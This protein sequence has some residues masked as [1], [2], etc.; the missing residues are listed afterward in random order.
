MRHILSNLRLSTL[1]QS[2]L[3]RLPEFLD[4]NEM[5]AVEGHVKKTSSANFQ[6]PDTLCQTT[7][8]R[9]PLI[10]ERASVF[11]TQA[12]LKLSTLLKADLSQ[13][14]DFTEKNGFYEIKNI[15]PL[16]CN[17]DTYIT[18]ISTI[19]PLHMS[20]GESDDD[21]QQE[22]SGSYSVLFSGKKV[23]MFSADE[24]TWQ[25]RLPKPLCIKKSSEHYYVHVELQFTTKQ[26]SQKQQLV[27]S[28]LKMCILS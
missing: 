6:L 21:G 27:L 23:G 11:I 24:E 18:K 19:A 17:K 5:M 26:W 15:L 16:T 12:M 3:K 1:E 4:A 13:Y 2:E 8:P 20:N 14:C 9:Q 10:H 28:L 7:M 25:V 22:S